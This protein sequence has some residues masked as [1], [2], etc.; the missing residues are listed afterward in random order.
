M[1]E[2]NDK[3]SFNKWYAPLDK[4]LKDKFKDLIVLSN[5]KLSA[6]PTNFF[7]DDKN[8]LEVKGESKEQTRWRLVNEWKQKLEVMDTSP[9][10]TK[11]EE[12]GDITDIT[13]IPETEVV[14]DIPTPPK[15][16]D[17]EVAK[18]VSAEQ[19][20]EDIA[21][22]VD[23]KQEAEPVLSQPTAYHGTVGPPA[24]LLNALSAFVASLDS[25]PEDK[26]ES[27]DLSAVI[28]RIE[29]LEEE[30]AKLKKKQ[31]SLFNAMRDL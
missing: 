23:N 12:R 18:N 19:E 31:A 11:E 15:P 28:E 5:P 13:D 25:P 22:A 14:N 7:T 9:V 4:A 26:A 10:V 8:V 20:A 29:K 30:N 27:A 2:I 6:N 3:L 1:S 16:K 17:I 21:T 24:D